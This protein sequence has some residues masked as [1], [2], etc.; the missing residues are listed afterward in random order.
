MRFRVMLFLLKIVRRNST[1]KQAVLTIVSNSTQE[2]KSKLT[3]SR[4]VFMYVIIT[5]EVPP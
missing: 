3:L 1:V 2:N 4:M 5:N